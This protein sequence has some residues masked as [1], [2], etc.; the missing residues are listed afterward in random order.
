MSETGN[1]APRA[2]SLRDRLSRGQVV[3]LDGATGTE[4]ERRGID[5]SLPLWSARALLEAPGAVRAVH[6]EYA[7]AGAQVLTANTF[8][9]QR[10]TLEA[11]GLGSRCVELTELA[12]RLAREAAGSRDIDVAGSAPPLED[13]YRPDLVPTAAELEREHAEHAEAL[14]RAGCDWILVETMNTIREARAAARAAAGTGLPFV[15]SFVSWEPG[16][17]LSGESL[18]DALDA[19]EQTQP[20]AMGVNCTPPSALP[21]ALEILRERND[22]FSVY[23]NLG[24]PLAGGEDLRSESTTPQHFAEQALR[25]VKEGARIIGGCCGT[26]PEHIAA[27]AARLGLTPP[28][29]GQEPPSHE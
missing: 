17:L 6:L 9:T 12:V 23:A 21:P 8:R 27:I 10:R 29:K 3:L 28:A 24:G 14:A 1:R 4:L 25:W 2:Q 5:S 16:R 7:L 11:S 26:R 20:V 18:R 15:V 19:L 13:C 22:P